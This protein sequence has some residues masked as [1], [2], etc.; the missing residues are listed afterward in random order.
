MNLQIILE[1]LDTEQNNDDGVY[2]EADFF[3][4]EDLEMN[5]R[6]ANYGTDDEEEVP[7]APVPLNLNEHLPQRNETEMCIVCRDEPHTHALVPCG[8]RVMCADCVSRLEFNRCPM[9]NTVF[10]LA[11][12]I[13]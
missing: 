3:V 2:N 9:C 7:Y 13:F 5:F 10:T 6:A 8:H 1:L 12:R 4:P 11:L